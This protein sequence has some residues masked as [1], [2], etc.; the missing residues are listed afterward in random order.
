LPVISPDL[1]TSSPEEGT[2]PNPYAKQ[3]TNYQEVQ[4]SLH[5]QLQDIKTQGGIKGRASMKHRVN[6]KKST[7]SYTTFPT[8]SRQ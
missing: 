4:D 6:S 2:V 7:Y 1:S 3:I 5:P 8:A